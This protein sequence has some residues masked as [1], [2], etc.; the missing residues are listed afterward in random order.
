MTGFGRAVARSRG[1][2]VEA[3]ARSVNSRYFDLILRLPREYSAMEGPLRE[4]AS[5]FVQ[6]GRLEITFN[7][8]ATGES[9]GSLKFD[10]G[11]FDRLYRIYEKELGGGQKLG[12][13]ERFSSIS[14]ILSRREVLDVEVEPDQLVKE[15][16]FVRQACGDA[17]RA[18]VRMRRRE[19]LRLVL[20]IKKWLSELERTRG[21]LEK[22][23]ALAPSRIK[24]RLLQRIARLSPEIRLDE[25]R[26]AC[27]VSLLA[28]RVDVTE[29]LVRLKAHL[30][31]FAASLK[32]GAGRKLDFLLQEIGRE[33]NTIGSKA[34]DAA[35]QQLVVSAKTAL[36][37][38]REQTQNL[39]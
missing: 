7:R 24:D 29:E 17:L 10:R 32:G 34:Q 13:L 9:R 37:K 6:R 15:E 39:E 14:A 12:D 22:L 5:S 16:R 20:D 4:L 33:F 18:L 30:K 26:L 23:A 2:S 19:G 36:E 38:I 31:E 11:L 21:K 3:E 8:R 28:D 1:L 25:V 27:E 35:A